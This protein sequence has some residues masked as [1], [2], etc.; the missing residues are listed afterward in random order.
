MNAFFF[1]EPFL[2]R[3]LTVLLVLA[4]AA[5][6]AGVLVNLRGREFI[7]DGLSHAMF[8]GLTAGLVLGGQSGV[9]PGATIAA[10]VGA[11]ALTLLTHWRV[12]SEA[13]TAIILTALFSVGVLIISTRHSYTAELES[14]LFGRVLTITDDEILPIII[15]AGIAGLTLLL[16]LRI[17]IL[18]TT[19]ERLLSQLTKP[20]IV[21][22]LLNC[23]LAVVVVAS[24]TALGAL[25]VLV[26][27]LVPGAV[28]RLLTHRLW[29][30]FPVAVGFAA[31]AAWLGLS[32][33]Y[34]SAINYHLNVP[35]GATIAAVFVT[36][37]LIVLIAA[38]T[39]RA[40]R[41]ART[42]RTARVARKRA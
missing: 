36:G 14:L 38:Q 24:A 28:S 3:A 41:T 34:L 8:P 31:L 23:C 18:A 4:V 10:L 9:L 27:L 32:V 22:L 11:I 2:V 33:G 17:Q 40:A 26:F 30:L 42:A 19:D 12:T 37:Y 16:T 29:L 39:A 21:N 20:L 1:T 6:I 25:L 35:P 5:G 15:L 7:S 13:A